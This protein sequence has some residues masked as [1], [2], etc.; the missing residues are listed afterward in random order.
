MNTSSKSLF[1]FKK[2][3]HEVKAIISTI[4]LIY[5]DWHQL[6][7]TIETNIIFQTVDPE[8]CPIFE[9]LGLAYPPH[10]VFDVSRKIFL[11]LYC[12]NW[13][14]CIVCLPLLL[15]YWAIDVLYS[16]VA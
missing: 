16:Y 4:T 13:P 1:V 9:G 10:F 14:N 11:N 6:V 8:I 2:A 3:L 12:I 15:R 7:H 5:F